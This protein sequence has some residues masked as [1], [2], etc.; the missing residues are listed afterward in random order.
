[1]CSFDLF[2]GHKYSRPFGFIFEYPGTGYFTVLAWVPTLV[3]VPDPVPDIIQFRPWSWSRSRTRSW[4]LYDPGLGP[5]TGPKHKAARLGG[6]LVLGR[7]HHLTQTSNWVRRVQD[8]A[9]GNKFVRTKQITCIKQQLMQTLVTWDLLSELFL[10]W[11]HQG[12]AA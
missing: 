3:P 5:C 12:K 6:G 1:M 9:P 7:R 2:Q 10:S 4:I 11:K 8:P